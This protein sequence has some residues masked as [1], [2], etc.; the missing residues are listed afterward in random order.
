MFTDFNL[1]I[2]ENRVRLTNLKS[3]EVFDR[4]S[5]V[6][7]SSDATL[8]ARPDVLVECLA[9]ALKQKGVWHRLATIPRVDVRVSRQLS[10]ETSLALTSSLSDMGFVRV[11]F[12]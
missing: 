8:V 10:E 11:R 9:D 4:R 2:S 1:T 7:F 6:H 3:G 5:P 12:I